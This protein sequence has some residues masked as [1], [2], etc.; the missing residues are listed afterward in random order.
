MEKTIKDKISDVRKN[1]I[2]IGVPSNKI[3][4]NLIYRSDIL[5]KAYNIEIYRLTEQKIEELLRANKLDLAFLNPISYCNVSSKGGWSIV[6]THCLAMEAFTGLI[7]IEFNRKSKVIKTI[8]LPENEAYLGAISKIILAERYDCFPSEF[9]KINSEIDKADCEIIFTD[10]DAS[11][12]IMD[13]SEIWFDTFEIPLIFGFWVSKSDNNNID[14]ISLTNELF[15][16]E[17]GDEYAII[18]N[19]TSENSDYQRVG[20]IHHKWTEDIKQ[21]LD[22]II[23]M[24]FALSIVQEVPE[25][26]VLSRNK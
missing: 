23:Q 20:N 9:K 15:N 4:D 18:E 1:L 7:S 13:L 11:S 8:S 19:N 12:S 16:D 5:K 17:I 10:P 6:P 2:K 25:I 26:K 22:E 3:Y 14:T 21:S 24:L